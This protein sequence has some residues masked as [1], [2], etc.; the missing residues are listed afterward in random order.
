MTKQQLRILGVMTGTSCDGLD[1]AC[2]QIDARKWTP[3]WNASLPYPK[4]LR[5]R[6][7]RFQLPKTRHTSR[8]WLELHR[9]LG[10]WYGTTLKK[11][12]LKNELCPDLI[13]NHGQTV[14]HFPAKN[15][16]GMSLQMGDSSR[17]AAITGLS[18]A[19]HFREGDLAVGGQGAPL[20]PL[21]HRLLLKLFHKKSSG[22]AIHNLGGMSNLTY[23]GPKDLVLGF[24]TGPANV[25]I[26]AATVKVTK[27]KQNID[28]NGNLAAQGQVD[29]RAL[30]EILHHP[31]FSKPAPK[32]TGRDEFPFSYFTART[33][34]RG[35]SLVAT[36]TE[37]TVESIARAYEDCIFKNH[38]PLHSISFC[39]GGAK[40][41]TLMKRLATRFP[42]INITTLDQQGLNSQFIEAQAFA[43]FGYLTL[44]GKPLG[45]PWTGA[46]EGGPPGHLIPGQNWAALMKKVLRHQEH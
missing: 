16:K 43:Y 44:L 19:S 38:L 30:R 21:F 10:D 15:S 45:G 8:D 27:G 41:Q 23:I 31:Y 32:S 29:S 28:W 14:A 7:L 2:I 24:D 20:V 1:A 35:P 11:L 33:K 39:G 9:D 25:W 12:I 17:I 13:A 36:A 4:S 46:K 6:V 37:V 34:A 5:T 3:L 22:V 26:D 42:Q 18:V 40:N